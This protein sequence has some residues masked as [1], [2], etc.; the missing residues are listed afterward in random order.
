M[1]KKRVKNVSEK[2]KVKKPVNPE[3]E[4]QLRNIFIFIGVLVVIFIIVYLTFQS[5]KKFE[6]AG[7]EFNKIMYDKLPLYYARATFVQKDNSIINYNLY[8]RNDPRKSTVIDDN[9]N[10]GFLVNKPIYI[11]L[12]KG[13]EMDC[14]SAG[15]IIDFLQFLTALGYKFEIVYNDP[16]LA[17]SKNQTVMTCEN[18][19]ATMVM[20]HA[21]DET[22]ITQFTNCYALNYKDC[23]TREV[24]ERLMLKIL[25][26]LNGIEI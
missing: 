7:L 4:R 10:I 15:E 8:L 5:M 20:Y 19:N 3:I 21:A 24:T 18:N 6:Y 17:S 23:E 22:R 14:G 1:A 16:V 2:L 26:K 13:A 9:V 12:D 25:A 11:S